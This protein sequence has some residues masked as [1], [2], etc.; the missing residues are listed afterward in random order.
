MLII[1]VDSANVTY[2]TAILPM[3]ML[4][5]KLFT[6]HF[7]MVGFRKWWVVWMKINFF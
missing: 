6:M 7:A 3:Q 2:T 4:A 1:N 5:T